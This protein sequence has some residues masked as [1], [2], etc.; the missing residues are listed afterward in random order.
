MPAQP[1]VNDNLGRYQKKKQELTAAVNSTM[2]KLRSQYAYTVSGTMPRIFT[3]ADSPQSMVVKIRSLPTGTLLDNAAQMQPIVANINREFTKLQRAVNS[4]NAQVK[5]GNK[6]IKLVWN[7]KGQVQASYNGQT[8]DRTIIIRT[9]GK[10][11]AAKTL[12]DKQRRVQTQGRAT[13]SRYGLVE[14]SDL[15]N[16]T[17]EYYGDVPISEFRE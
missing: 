12:A 7:A 6:P 17:I 8:T 1:A 10:N 15:V 4:A 11:A 9:W 14:H 13:E 3:V 5:G 16:A 2:S